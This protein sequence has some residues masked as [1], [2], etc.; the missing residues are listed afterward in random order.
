M[1]DKLNRD[2]KLIAL[3][4]DGTLLNEKQ[5]ISEGNRQ[6]IYKAREK[7]VTVILSTG[8]SILTCQEYAKSLNLLSYVITVNGSEIWERGQILERNPLQTELVQWMW[9]LSQSY[10]TNYWATSTDHVWRNQIPECIANHQ[11]LKFGFEIEDDEIRE[12]VLKLLLNQSQLEISNSSP[13]N[14]EIN[15]AGINKASAIVKVCERLNISMENVM[16]IGD[17]L[18]DIA[19]IQQSGLGIAMG[20]AQKAVKESADWVTAS[21]IEDGVSEAIRYWIL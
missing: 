4:M 5:E 9:E 1:N 7:G 21:N 11:W 16:A 8:R 3:D 18:N 13:V 6:A 2:I 10:K 17:S 20:N 14:I 12:S 19:M 15:A